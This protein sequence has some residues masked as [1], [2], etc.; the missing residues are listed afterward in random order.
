MLFTS[1]IYRDSSDSLMDLLDTGCLD[2]SLT[3]NA[4]REAGVARFISGINNNDPAARKRLNCKA[5]R[6]FIVI[7]NQNLSTKNKELVFFFGIL[8]SSIILSK[9]LLKG[10]SRNPHQLNTYVLHFHS[11]I[12]VNIVM[13]DFMDMKLFCYGHYLVQFDTISISVTKELQGSGL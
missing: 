6:Y 2:T 4:S 8:Y 9:T 1:T 7:I 3:V 5:L 11:S 13:Q 12:R 10:S